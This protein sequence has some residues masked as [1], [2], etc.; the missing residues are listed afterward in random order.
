MNKEIIYS[1]IV[2]IF[3]S[4]ESL[5][6]LVHRIKNTLESY[7]DTYEIILIDDGSN[8]D[9]WEVISQLKKENN[10]LL[11]TICFTKNFGQ[12]NA[13]LC[14]IEKAIGHYIITIDDDLQVPPEEIS[15]LI[16]A[17]KTT[18]A[19]LIYGYFADKK[20]S[21]F[22]NMG[23]A[24]VKKTGKAIYNSPG[25]GSSFRLIKSDLA[26]KIVSHLQSFVYIDEILLW[27][28]HNIHFIKV[29]HVPRKYSKSGYSASK[30]F[31]MSA[32]IVFYY[33]AMPL[34]IMVY[35]GIIC[36][37]LSFLTGI[38]FIIRKVL[39]K[40]PHG[41]TSLIVAILF[42]TGVIILCLGI[43]GEYLN[44][45]YI[46]QNKKPPYAIREVQD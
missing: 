38:Y 22:R 6:E 41:Y 29:D 16:A 28:T 3:N 14:G 20:H 36:S 5:E 8:D 4:A 9:S 26:K 30:L 12:H 46:V 23:S 15:K 35:S 11:K 40:V 44:R 25:E 18:Q 13:V 42:S 32:N 45:I 24:I 1:V 34:K 17:S 2:P 21:F 19:D 43:I 39:F 33:T 10:A 31:S 27:Y 7:Q 37:I